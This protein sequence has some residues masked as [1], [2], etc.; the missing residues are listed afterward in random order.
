M[1]WKDVQT[2]LYSSLLVKT[3]VLLNTDF[4]HAV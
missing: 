1:D 4:E 2:D 3:G